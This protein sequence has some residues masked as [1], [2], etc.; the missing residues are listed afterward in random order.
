MKSSLYK[1]EDD[2]ASQD[3]PGITTTV[4]L[5]AIVVFTVSGSQTVPILIESANQGRSVDPALI[6]AFLLNIALVLLAWRRSVQLRSTSA[7]RDAAKSYAET[8]AYR[9]EVTGLANRRRLNEALERLCS[10]ESNDAALLLIDLDHFKKI[11]DLY[12]H[13]AGDELLSVVAN[14]L[15]N[16]SPPDAMCF[17]QGGDE[18][19]VL[20]RGKWAEAAEA[21][22]LGCSLQTEIAKPVQVANTVTGIGSSIGIA[23]LTARCRAPRDLLKRADLAMYEAKRLGRNRTVCF[24]AAMETDLEQRARLEA[25][26][27]L[28]IESGEFVPYFQ[29]IYDLHAGELRGFEVLARWNHPKRGLIG[30]SEF[31]ELAEAT[32]MIAEL[33][34]S[35]MH[36][37]LLKA[38]SWPSD[39]TLAVNVSPVQFNDPLLAERILHVLESTDFP[40]SRLELEI[41]EKSLLDEQSLALSIIKTLKNSGISISVDDFGTGYAL[42]TDLKS[43]PFDRIKIDRRFMQSLVNEQNCD[44]LV[45]AVSS[46]GK[47]LKLPMTAEGVESEAVHSKLAALG[48]T[49]AQGWLFAEALSAKEVG[50][51]FATGWISRTDL[52]TKVTVN[53]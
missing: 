6:S 25:D 38:R 46:L 48:C 34:F 1:L 23:R 24:S 19:A 20:L 53:S 28:G 52:P 3:D 40:G 13:A 35:V 17:R 36:Q 7:E 11:N 51:S 41:M 39:L 15:V 21:E 45:Q 43:L 22:K 10:A 31:M 44:A 33:S 16:A 26:M 18:F 50:L 9:D 12:G 4:A 32:G 30:P 2:R 14:R 29:P 49:D 5:L 47:G 8:L 37:A 27:R 42:L